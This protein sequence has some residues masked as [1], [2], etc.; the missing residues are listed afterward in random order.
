[1]ETPLY[2][3]NSV[4]WEH[5]F[6]PVICWTDAGKIKYKQR[7]LPSLALNFGTPSGSGGSLLPE[8]SLPVG[9]WWPPALWCHVTSNCLC[10]CSFSLTTDY[11]GTNT[12]LYS[13]LCS[14]NPTQSWTGDTE[15]TDGFQSSWICIFLLTKFSFQMENI[16]FFS[17]IARQ[18]GAMEIPKPKVRYNFEKG[19]IS[20][21]RRRKYRI[22]R[23]TETPLKI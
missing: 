4:N 18:E 20:G 8:E 6:V 3:W 5:I 17:N 23:D 11:L 22:S 9:K 15:D 19:K 10:A 14:Q 1:M 16:C 13:W 12:T 21:A 7:T 2:F